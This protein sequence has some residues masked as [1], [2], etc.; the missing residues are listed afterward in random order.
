MP[1]SS[2]IR[3]W[4]TLRY[5]AATYR[6]PEP[7]LIARLGLPA[8]TPSDTTLKS[9]ADREGVSRFSYVR[10]VQQT[11]AD[12]APGNPS[13][14]VQGSGSWLGWLQ[15]P[16]LSAPIVYGYPILGLTLL[17]GAIGSPSPDRAVGGQQCIGL[18]TQAWLRPTAPLGFNSSRP[19]PPWWRTS[20]A[21][22]PPQPNQ[23]GGTENEHPEQQDRQP[24]W[25]KQKFQN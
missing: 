8:D 14:D 13:R 6:A 3:A 9:L 12:V 10:R 16:F 19:A 1:Q 4:M 20:A 22:L 25:P 17:F 7:L 18:I 2:S 24:L 23:I 11:I 5:V 15:E 21:R